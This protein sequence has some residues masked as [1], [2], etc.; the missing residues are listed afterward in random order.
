MDETTSQ[1]INRDIKNLNKTSSQLDLT[2][3]YR[4]LHLR[5]TEYTFF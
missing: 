5:T 4:A 2:D 1:K 3:T